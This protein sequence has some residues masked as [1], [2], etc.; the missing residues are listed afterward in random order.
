MSRTQLRR[1]AKRRR[2][3]RFNPKQYNDLV[4]S[5][6]SISVRFV[7]EL[8]FDLPITPVAARYRS[9]RSTMSLDLDREEQ[10]LLSGA[11]GDGTALAMRI[12]ACAARVLQ[13][14]NLT[15]IH[16]AHIDG[17]LYHGD[18][19]V[20]F[21]ERLVALG[22]RV[23]VPTTLNVGAIDLLHGDRD[24]LEPAAK[25]MARR[26]MNAYVAMGAKPT[27]TCA[28]YQA[29]H[30]PRR[31]EDVAWGESNAVAFCN[32]VLG[33]RTN[34][35]GDFL[36]ICAA[37]TGR[38]P[39]TG[40]HLPEN[41]VATVLV[42]ATGIPQ[43]YWNQDIAYPVLGTWLG[44]VV[45]E[46]VAAIEGIG[47]PS[48]DQLKALGAAAASSG[49]VG[50][51]HV[52][53]TTPEAPS[54]EV[55]F[56]NRPP[57]EVIRLDP[58]TLENVRLTLSSV[59]LEAGDAVNAVAVGSPHLS[60]AE[61]LLLDR[62]LGNRQ[63]AIPLYA[64]TGRH[65]VNEFSAEDLRSFVDRGVILVADTCI[66]VTPILPRSSGVVVT[67]SGK[68]AHYTPSNTGYDVVFANFRDC[69]ESAVTGSLQ[70]TPSFPHAV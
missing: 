45:G 52:I 67:N 12:V 50:L 5:Y 17:C 18:S 51:F 24:R 47:H 37:I 4:I 21:A 9:F 61:L 20:L 26:L 55:A 10:H 53:G 14:E 33:A 58:S 13:A 44:H 29:G 68:F 66:V 8:M 36:D 49:A 65:V 7:R 23:R 27:W 32:S 43:P 16:A 69:I 56:G 57:S 35:Y 60:K 19:G 22:A 30:R 15:P 28:P 59:R 2:G 64:C 48:E 42:D 25:D 31:G 40:L 41:R 1:K 54:L 6:G 3:G 39:R 34:R 38:A 11:E 63:C 46:R 70:L 62:L